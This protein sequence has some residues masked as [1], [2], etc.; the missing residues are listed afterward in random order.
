VNAFQTASPCRAALATALVFAAGC[1]SAN[2]DLATVTKSE[3]NVESTALPPNIARIARPAGSSE[4]KAQSIVLTGAEE[5]DQ[6]PKGVADKSSR[7]NKADNKIP[8][9]G[10]RLKV[11]EGIPGA[12]VQELKLPDPEREPEAYQRELNNLFPKLGDTP[13]LEIGPPGVPRARMTLAELEQM[14]LASSPIIDQFQSDITAQKGE[15][16]Q[17]GTHPNPII[18]YESDTVGSSLTRNY[19]GVYISQ[20]IKTGGKLELQQAIQNVD[21]MNAQLMLRQA[22]N[23]LL[24]DVRREYF[25]LLIARKALEINQAVVTFTRDVY[26]IQVDQ[27]KGGGQAAVYEPLQLLTLA[28]QSKGGLVAAWNDYT[29]AWKQLTAT[30]NIPDLQPADLVD[31]PDME[32]PLVDFDAAVT[33]VLSMNTEARAA[34][35]GPLRAKLALKLAEKIPIPDVFAYGT[36]QRDFTVPTLGRTTY[37]TQIGIPVPIFDRNKGG[38]LAA[39]GALVRATREVPRVENDLRA[40]LADAFKRYETNRILVSYQRDQ[41][42]PNSVRAYRGT[43]QRHIQGPGADVETTEQEVGFAD[44]IVAQQNLLASVAAYITALNAQWSA[45]VD[46]AALLQIDTLAELQL[47]LKQQESEPAP[48]EGSD[49]KDD[50]TALISNILT[51]AKTD[52]AGETLRA[53]SDDKPGDK[54]VLKSVDKPAR[55]PV[56]QTGAS[57]TA[58]QATAIP[59]FTDDEGFESDVLEIPSDE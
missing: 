17:A 10:N 39:T 37:N 41:I 56:V 31:D 50:V 51:V 44:V 45:L 12:H 34:R 11:P 58:A 36:F 15:A 52:R 59:S 42:L 28:V 5:Q 4:R 21:V 2:R 16:I 30:L 14:A 49:E 1:A 9:L 22:R 55:T 24:S 7:N 20:V 23:D 13:V 47:K 32:V 57:Q 29:S 8:S 18:G 25:A 35:N 19:Q 38:I 54:A 53:K 33:H 3:A 43:Y 6:P 48:V 27:V 26:R 46:I 40:R